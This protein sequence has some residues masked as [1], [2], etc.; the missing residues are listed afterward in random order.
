M[1]LSKV[2]EVLPNLP[3]PR[4]LN[5]PPSMPASTVGLANAGPGGAVPSNAAAANE[6]GTMPAANTTTSS[7]PSN[8]LIRL[9]AAQTG[10]QLPFNAAQQPIMSAPTSH[11]ED[12]S[13]YGSAH[14]TTQSSESGP[15][16]TSTTP[17]PYE[18]SIPPPRSQMVGH[19][20]M[21]IPT[22]YPHY[23]QSHH[24]SVNQTAYDP[25]FSLQGYP[26]DPAMTF[27]Q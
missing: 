21:Q 18:P 19:S 27:K 12:L 13:L 5:L 3:L 15:R 23:T 24:V 14:S 26:V 22:S 2:S 6:Y 4:S 1:L 8:D 20:T 7:Y 25:R 17:N 11:V 9:L 10:A 16:S